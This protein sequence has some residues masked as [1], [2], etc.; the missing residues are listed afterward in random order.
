[1]LDGVGQQ[2]GHHLQKAVGVQRHLGLGAAGAVFQQQRHVVAR[3]ITLVRGQRLA[4]QGPHTLRAQVQRQAVALQLGEVEHVVDEPAQPLAVA[5]RHLG[6]RHRRGRQRTGSAPCD[7]AQSPHHRG[8]RR[9]Q[10]VAHGGQELVLHAF[11][12]A[13]L[14]QVAQ[15]HG[16]VHGVVLAPFAQAQLGRVGVAFMVAD[17]AFAL[18][19]QLGQLDAEHRGTR[20]ARRERLA[21]APAQCQRGAVEFLHAARGVE[22]EHRVEDVVEDVA[23]ALRQRRQ[24]RLQ[25]QHAAVMAQ[26]GL[27]KFRVD[28]AREVVVGAAAQRVDDVLV[29]L[30]RRGDDDGYPV[31]PGQ[32]AQAARDLEAV[33]PRHQQV[34]Q[35]QVGQAALHLGQCGRPAIGPG[36]AMAEFGDEGA[37]R[38]ARFQDVVDDQDVHSLG[39][40]DQGVGVPGIV[41]RAAGAEMTPGPGGLTKL[42]QL[43]GRPRL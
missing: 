27:K 35:H 33:E 21:V 11:D 37:Q 23:L 9:A 32:F 17:R 18:H 24:A 39:R 34:E 13:A 42:P 3:R 30:Q 7:E 4:Q 14:G 2:I 10:F 16:V 31:S 38:A 6:Q 36:G 5:P 8:Q 28:G 1:M 19:Q 15:H 43:G 12:L 20:A 22:R 40:R 26:L 41:A 29:A 25:R